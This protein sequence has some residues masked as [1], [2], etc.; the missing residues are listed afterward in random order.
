MSPMGEGRS[1]IG[2]GIV[3]NGI[4]LPPQESASELHPARF[5]GR[6][7]IISSVEASNA[8]ERGPPTRGGG[9]QNHGL[10]PER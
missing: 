2:K 4:Y 7:P 1:V 8:A 3:P 9:T 10:L 5:D 6:C